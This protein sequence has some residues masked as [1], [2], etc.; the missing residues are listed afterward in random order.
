MRYKRLLAIVVTILLFIPLFSFSSFGLL[1]SRVYEDG[2]LVTPDSNINTLAPA[3]PLAASILT[4]WF[5]SGPY[6]TDF[7]LPAGN[8]SVVVDVISNN[9]R[10]ARRYVFPQGS[11]A[12]V[13][14]S[15]SSNV[16]FAWTTENPKDCL[17]MYTSYDY[18]TG[19]FDVNSYSVI[20]PTEA[21]SGKYV[22]SVVY[23]AGGLVTLGGLVTNG[24][25][26]FE[27]TS[28]S[29]LGKSL[30]F[31]DGVVLEEKKTQGMISQLI[32]D[33]KDWF[34]NLI[35]SMGNF[36][37]ESVNKI[38]DFFTK[39]WNK[40]WW[41]NEAGE[42]EYEPPDVGSKFDDVID[43]L[44]DWLSQLKGF[45]DTVNNQGDEVAGYI[46]TGSN[47]VTKFLTYAPAPILIFLTFGVVFV[48]VRKV[49]GR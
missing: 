40:I 30:A 9:G 18:N 12:G 41:G 36:F 8:D 5:N 19:T 10:Y 17:Y 20:Y 21:S 1:E 15:S 24:L 16:T 44:N 3:A 37:T 26:E 32:S 33:I 46:S 6:A 22:G 47:A 7:R 11:W 29:S 14:I 34:S 23:A 31:P 39:L 27:N 45:S 13:Y 43:S 4:D 35:E 42:S 48:V 38:G 49:V 2:Y 25:I 28:V